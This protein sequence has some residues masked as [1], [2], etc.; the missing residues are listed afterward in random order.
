MPSPFGIITVHRDQAVSRWIEGKPIL[1]YN[2]INEVTKKLPS[3]ETN[4]EKVV[5]PRAE[6]TEDTHKAPLFELM[7]E[8]CVHVGSNFV[9][10]EK[11]SMVAFLHENQDV[12]TE[13]AK[14]LQGV[15]RDLTQHS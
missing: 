1:G 10:N 12:F 8:K 11:D 6:A 2:L 9:K 4:S 13:S 5:E 7:L 3:K 14:D 15:S